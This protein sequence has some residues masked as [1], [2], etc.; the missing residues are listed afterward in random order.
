MAKANTASVAEAKLM[1]ANRPKCCAAWA[2]SLLAVGGINTLVAAQ[3]MN[4][5]GKG[6]N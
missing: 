1:D 4:I 5:T 6:S 2:A 3:V